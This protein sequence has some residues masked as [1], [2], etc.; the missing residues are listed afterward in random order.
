MR[1]YSR[2]GIAFAVFF[3]CLLAVGGC[4]K[5]EPLFPVSGKATLKNAP[6]TAGMVTFV[7]DDAKGNKTKSNPS[8][9]IGSD[10]TYT[11]TTEG[12]SGAPLGWY[13][14]TVITDTPGMGGPMTV[15]PTP[16][17]PAPLGGTSA[18]PPIDPKYKDSAKTP[19]TI[20]VVAAPAAGAYDVKI[21]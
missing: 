5:S 3:P 18:G 17:K 14:V 20:E 4:A 7:P 6:L 8:G 16:G 11:L 2:F 10:G 15:D 9:K 21:P 12:K 1:C 19:L 13:K